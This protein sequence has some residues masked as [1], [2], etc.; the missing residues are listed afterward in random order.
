MLKLIELGELLFMR[1]IPAAAAAAAFFIAGRY[2]SG[3]VAA[4]LKHT[5]TRFVQRLKT[6]VKVSFYVVGAAVTLGI[7]SLNYL[8]L[9]VFLIFVAIGILVSFR[10]FLANA[11][12]EIY[13][14]IRAP[15]SEGEWIRIGDFEGRITAINVFDV[16]LTTPYGEKVIIPN[17]LFLKNL[18]IRKI[19]K[20]GKISEVSFMVKGAKPEK[21]ESTI[22]EAL[23]TIRSEL[24]E[25]GEIRKIE[26]N[27][28][29]VK[30]TLTLP[31]INVLKVKKLTE[32]LVGH[33]R[34]KGYEAEAL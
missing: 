29:D 24:F 4:S 11:A 13:L 27:G 10:D 9:G 12:G 15:F 14:R 25:D 17:S 6:A 2:I 1:V 23:Q 3:K 34:R 26:K 20:L 5:E 33:L 32:E 28:K 31:V 18:S 16:E 21:V 7:L 19:G 30:V 22:Y 8:A